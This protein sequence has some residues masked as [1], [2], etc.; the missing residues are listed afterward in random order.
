M[1]QIKLL[2][3]QLTPFFSLLFGLVFGSFLN[4]CIYRIPLGR[5]KG[6]AAFESDEDDDKIVEARS[7]EDEKIRFFYPR[8]SICPNC[9]NTLTWLMNIP[10]FSWLFLRGRCHFCKEKISWRYPLVEILSGIL[11]CLSF[12]SFPPLTATVIFFF[13]AAMIVISFIDLEYY[14]IPNLITYPGM[15]LAILLA[16]FN[17]FQPTVLDAPLVQLQQAGLGLLVGGGFLWLVS[18]TYTLIRKKEGL[19]FGDVK[20]MAMV[21]L[22]FGPQAAIVGIFLGSTLG[23]IIGVLYISL[24]KANFS[25]PLPFGPFLAVGSITYVFASPL[26]DNLILPLMGK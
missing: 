5:P 1:Y 20:L 26:M 19:G 6:L 22:L 9:K 10:V 18:A 23:T 21:G 2:L 13:C 4:V 8:R 15:L 16:F 25:R 11:C 3:I 7:A 12:T 17:Q 14:I 24:T